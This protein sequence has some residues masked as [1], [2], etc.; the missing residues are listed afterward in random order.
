MSNRRGTR[1]VVK[2]RV[3]NITAVL[4]VSVP[5]ALSA[6]PASAAPRVVSVKFDR[7]TIV[8]KE[9]RL[10]LS[11]ID[12]AAPVSGISVAFSS[13]AELFALSACRPPGSDGAPP[14]GPFAAGAPV[15]LRVPH[16]FTRT[17]AQALVAR[18]DS[19]GCTE[20]GGTV[21]QPVTVT[22]T[23]PGRPLIPPLIGLP[24]TLPGLL[25]PVPG[26]PGG[27]SLPGLPGLPGLT[28]AA[29][30][31]D[32]LGTAAASCPGERTPVGNTRTARRNG[33]RALLCLMNSFR[34]RSGL[35][36]LLANRRLTRAAAAHSRSMV[37]GRYFAHTG[38]GGPVLAG[39]LRRVRYLPARRWLIG[40][41]LATSAG[42][43]ATP[44]SI[45]RAWIRS[46]PHRANLLE[47]T[48]REVGLGL[49]PGQ[50]RRSARRGLTLT[51]DFGFRR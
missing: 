41:N 10:A 8:G 2:T 14:G 21:Y 3:W 30:E 24:V 15:T 46:S 23:P 13:P 38:P 32:P 31:P 11:A 18:V 26:L 37:R 42:R 50:P 40:E 51:A 12:P 45:L 1:P 7:P 39:R 22:P 43:A 19:G 48:F 20:K 4:W 5:L 36:P 35:R 17:G 44:V 47:S 25:P 6:A 9:S 28:S 29:D 16:T 34:R 27:I 33:R 49:V